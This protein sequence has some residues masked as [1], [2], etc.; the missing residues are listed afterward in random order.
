MA[1]TSS[2]RLKLGAIETFVCDFIEAR[3]G[4]GESCGDRPPSG[5]KHSHAA[6]A[7]AAGI[8]PW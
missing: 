2:A 4:T 5:R 3:G 1:N 6:S 8:Q 7:A